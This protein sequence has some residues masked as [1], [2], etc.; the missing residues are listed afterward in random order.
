M[1]GQQRDLGEGTGLRPRMDNAH[2]RMQ[3]MTIRVW[4]WVRWM[5]PLLVLAL[6]GC[7][8]EPPASPVAT[9]VPAAATD[10]PAVATETPAPDPA[11]EN[12]GGRLVASRTGAP[13]TIDGH[14]E[15]AWDGAEPLT[16]PLTW[17][18]EGTRHAFDVELRA[19][20]DDR[21]IYLLARWPGDLVPGEED[22]VA[23]KLTLHWRLPESAAQGLNCTVVCHTAHVDGRGRFVYANAETIP[24]GGAG[25]LSAAG[26]W[27]AQW[28]TLEWSRPLISENPYDLQFDDRNPAYVFFLKVF[29]GVE[30][31][32]DPASARHAMVFAP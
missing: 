7:A 4:M 29:E 13:V 2:R 18:V 10:I 25:A 26:Q 31:S 6:I 24:Q 12:A 32:P 30:G 17:G 3:S 20:Y 16:V 23:N 15:K 9:D 22:V 5:A 11:H 1:P 28:W 8:S 19:L 27:E 14:V 21:S